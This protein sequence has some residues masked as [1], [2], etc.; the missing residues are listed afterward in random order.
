[1]IAFGSTSL[2]S[3][4]C[5]GSDIRQSTAGENSNGSS[6]APA[7]LK[8]IIAQQIEDL[9]TDEMKEKIPRIADFMMIH[10]SLGAGHVRIL[11][12]RARHRCLNREAD[13]GGELHEKGYLES[14]CSSEAIRC[15][16]RTRVVDC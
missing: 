13:T 4:R 1:M 15:A 11:Y 5:V 2:S 12:T 14:I 10:P 8:R 9:I 3:R 16:P 6:E 7:L